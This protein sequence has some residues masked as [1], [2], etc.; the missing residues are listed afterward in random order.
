VESEEQGGG[1]SAA[2]FLGEEGMPGQCTC[3]LEAVPAAAPLVARGRRSW[4]GPTR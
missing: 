4:V 1:G 2:P 3:T